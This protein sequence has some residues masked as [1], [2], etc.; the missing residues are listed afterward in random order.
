MDVCEVVLDAPWLRLLG[1]I[2]WDFAKL[3]MRFKWKN[4]EVELRGVKLPVH[5]LVEDKDMGREVKR[6]KCGWVCH[7]QPCT[8]GTILKGSLHAIVLGIQ[9][10]ETSPTEQKITSIL[11]EFSN[12]FDEPR[13][14][15]PTRSHDHQI[16]LTIGSGPTNMRPYRYPHYQ[17]NE[18]EKIVLGL[19]QSGIVSSSNSP[20]SS[21]VILV[22]KHDGS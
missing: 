6:R 11:R 19:L 1:P 9:Q 2:W 3:L 10:K 4:R 12:L 21:P 15:P 22:K 5:R 16:V 13:G 8:P 7:I 18:I 20:Y 14:L 17:K